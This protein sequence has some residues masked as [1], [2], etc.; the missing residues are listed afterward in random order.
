MIKPTI[1]SVYIW[2]R[3]SG[4]GIVLKYKICN[5]PVG[6]NKTGTQTFHSLAALRDE[7][8]LTRVSS[9][10]IGIGENS[11]ANINIPLSKLE[12]L[13]FTVRKP[14]GDVSL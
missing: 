13:G 1:V 4:S 10:V 5:C 8:A 7:L 3:D 9:S 6:L 11:P 14:T 2:R 12:Q